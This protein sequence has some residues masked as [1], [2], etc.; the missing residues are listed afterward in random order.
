V[1]L[2][3]RWCWSCGGAGRAVVLVVR[4]CPDRTRA[5][6]LLSRSHI[7]AQFVICRVYMIFSFA[8]QEP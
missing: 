8:M 3:V 7:Y 4:W 2:V 6:V 5:A 1:V